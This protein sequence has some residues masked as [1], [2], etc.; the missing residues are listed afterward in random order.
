MGRLR[1]QIPHS[2]SNYGLF[3]GDQSPRLKEAAASLN[4]ESSKYALPLH[5]VHVRNR[6]I[7]TQTKVRSSSGLEDA[8]DFLDG[9]R[10]VR[11]HGSKKSIGKNKVNRSVFNEAKVRCRCGTRLDVAVS[12][13][14]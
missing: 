9:Q 10:P 2:A 4:F 6:T 1:S 8:L 5:S 7:G 14:V 3:C 13:F 11:N 12:T